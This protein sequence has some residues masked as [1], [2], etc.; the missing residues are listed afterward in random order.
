MSDARKIKSDWRRFW[1]HLII[2]LL[3]IISAW[4]WAPNA[5]VKSGIV[6]AGV[7]QAL[8]WAEPAPR[9]VVGAQDTGIIAGI[10]RL[11]SSIAQSTHETAY[12]AGFV[13]VNAMASA[14]IWVLVFVGLTFRGLLEL[15]WALSDL[16]EIGYK[17]IFGG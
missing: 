8:T 7:R 2:G 12:E 14:L 5:V 17:F 16:L 6:R 15:R 11:G 13:V 3:L 1:D 10:K 9:S 4:T